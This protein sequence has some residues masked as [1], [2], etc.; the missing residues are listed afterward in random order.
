MK[1]K[2]IIIFSVIL[3][4][5]IVIAIVTGNYI[6]SN[7]N[8]LVEYKE[9]VSIKYSDVS[10]YLERRAD[11]IPNLVNTIKGYT[12][13][14]EEV[15]TKV[16]EARK[17]LL[18]ADNIQD[19]SKANDELNTAIRALMIVVEKYPD[20]KAST[21]FI[22]LQDEL[23][24]TENRIATARKDYNRAVK[25]YNTKIKKFPINI[26]ANFLSFKE[27]EYF[28]VSDKKSEVPNIEF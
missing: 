9:S 24:G 22:N 21:Q 1:K 3:L 11:L 14:E 25:K 19:K 20:I 10:I 12:Q 4:F 5:I 2:S 27:V 8:E 17:N 7:Y 23:A 13:H 16:S 18:S 26:I 15:L 6:A 28:T